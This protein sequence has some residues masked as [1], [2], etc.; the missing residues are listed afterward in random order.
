M[1]RLGH[2]IS[3]EINREEISILVQKVWAIKAS[4]YSSLDYCESK[5]REYT[6]ELEPFKELT[7]KLKQKLTK[8]TQSKFKIHRRLD[9]K[10]SKRP[11]DNVINNSYEL[12]EEM[13]YLIE[14][15]Y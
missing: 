12:D 13:K 6:D 8:N 1:I 2:T 5:A 14:D 4:R 3:L 7:V 10:S 15:D 9:S 11:T